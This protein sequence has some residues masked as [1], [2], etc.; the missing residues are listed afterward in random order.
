MPILSAIVGAVLLFFGERLYWLF[1]GGIGFVVG[2][3]LAARGLAGQPEWIILLAAVLVG[4]V[5]AVLAIFF[6]R[7]AIGLAGFMAGGYLALAVLTNLT[8]SATGQASMIAFV[9]GGIVVAV[10]VVAL[11]D[12]ALIVISALVGA[13]MIS[14]RAVHDALWR[15]VTFAVLFV[16]GVLVQ[17][18]MLRRA[19]PRRIEES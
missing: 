8:G 19:G 2:M 7:L 15:T 9:I 5:G 3:D 6:Q 12:W 18:A 17:A 13:A 14:Q 1:V 11:L 10:L 16:A 4:I